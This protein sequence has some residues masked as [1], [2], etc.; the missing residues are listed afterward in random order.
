M[1]AGDSPIVTFG[2]NVRPIDPGLIIFGKE[3]QI[4]QCSLSFTDQNFSHILQLAAMQ[5]A[6]LMWTQG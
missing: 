5:A 2:L 1:L 3:R 4:G 6:S